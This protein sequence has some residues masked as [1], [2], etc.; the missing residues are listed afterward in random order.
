MVATKVE[1]A[2]HERGLWLQWVLATTAGFIVGGFAAGAAAKAMIEAHGGDVIGLTPWEGAVVGAVAG[3]AIGIGQ[4]L[5]LR[6]RIAH[7]G[8]WV[9]A[10]IVG[11]IVFDAVLAASGRSNPILGASGLALAALAR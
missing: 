9:L 4:W 6:R 8:W 3:L 1:G 7:A 5:V 11:W 2:Q 10:I